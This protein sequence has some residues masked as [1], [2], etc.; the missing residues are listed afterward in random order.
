MLLMRGLLC[1]D[2]NP[3]AGGAGL[4][5]SCFDFAGGS[6]LDACPLGSGRCVVLD[7]DRFKAVLGDAKRYR[8]TFIV[9]SPDRERASGADLLQQ[10]GADELIDNLSGGCA[11]GVPRQFNSA[12]IPLGSRGQND[13]LRIGES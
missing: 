11:L 12:I 3:L 7:L 13:E 9:A 5:R 2:G 10:A 4:G 6:R 8:S 1:H